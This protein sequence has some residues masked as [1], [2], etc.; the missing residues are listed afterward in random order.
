MLACYDFTYQTDRFYSRIF[1]LADVFAVER[2]LMKIFGLY[3]YMYNMRTCLVCCAPWHTI[4]P[5][6]CRLNWHIY[7]VQLHTRGKILYVSSKECT[8]LKATDLNEFW[9]KFTILV[10]IDFHNMYCVEFESSKNW[11]GI[12]DFTMMLFNSN[13]LWNYLLMPL[14]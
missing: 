3:I 8:F 5:C 6:W 9:I 12:I 7:D 11:L 4:L 10:E 13:L 1:F 2:I 14:K